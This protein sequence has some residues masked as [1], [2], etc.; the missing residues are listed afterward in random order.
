MNHIQNQILD[1]EHKGKYNATSS[2]PLIFCSLHKTDSSSFLWFFESPRQLLYGI[3]EPIPAIRQLGTQT[4]LGNPE[5][6]SS[7]A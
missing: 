2:L 6:R 7:N 5:L 4:H 1:V 3:G